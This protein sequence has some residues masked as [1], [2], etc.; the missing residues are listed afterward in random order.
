MILRQ[1][2]P[3]FFRSVSTPPTQKSTEATT[4]YY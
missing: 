1:N 4:L 2:F 3:S